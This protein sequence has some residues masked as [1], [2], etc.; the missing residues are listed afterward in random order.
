MFL[1]PIL[2]RLPLPALA[3]LAAFA[4]PAI[5]QPGA[6]LAIMSP[7]SEE[8]VHDNTGQVGV[9][10]VVDDGGALAQGRAVLRVLL[11]GALFGAGQ[12]GLSFRLE[13]IERGT[14]TLQV[15]LVDRDGKTVAAS[16]PVTFH[17]WQ[18][19]ALFPARKTR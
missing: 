18:A 7:A 15:Q 14:H 17:M 5:G 4:L 6:T 9:T 16:A 1:R 2:K 3:L 8:T 13:G 11:D 10:V 12:R 19:S